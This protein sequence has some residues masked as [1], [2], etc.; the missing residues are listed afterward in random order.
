VVYA[1]IMEALPIDIQSLIWQTFYTNHV[2]EEFTELPFAWVRITQ[3][4]DSYGQLKF[5]LQKFHLKNTTYRCWPI[6]K[7]RPWW[8]WKIDRGK[9]K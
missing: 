2:M 9:H 8:W 7:D 3:S 5:I 6:D 1:V 4:G